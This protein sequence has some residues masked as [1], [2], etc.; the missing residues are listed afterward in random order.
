MINVQICLWFLGKIVGISW[1]LWISCFNYP[2]DQFN[3]FGGIGIGIFTS[4]IIAHIGGDGAI[5]PKIMVI[6]VT[7]IR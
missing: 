7:G 2:T 6:Q 4:S 3:W 5:W 1:L